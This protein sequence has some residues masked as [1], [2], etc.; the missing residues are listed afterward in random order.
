MKPERLQKVLSQAGVTSRRKAESLI[1]QG[2][3]S[4]NGKVVR[5]LG[6]KAVWGGSVTRGPGPEGVQDRR[7]TSR[8][9]S[10]RKAG[11]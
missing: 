10:R 5:E 9:G 1:L 2:R 7:E 3:V 11:L 4:V 6:A 8:A